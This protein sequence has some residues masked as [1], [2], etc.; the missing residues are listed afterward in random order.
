[1][2]GWD[3]STTIQIEGQAVLVESEERKRL[4]DVH[5]IKNELSNK[6]RNDPR[7]EYFKIIPYWIRYFDFSIDPQEVWEVR[8]K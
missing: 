8:L 3:N 7:Q 5:C 4:E 1:M 2:V 6:Y